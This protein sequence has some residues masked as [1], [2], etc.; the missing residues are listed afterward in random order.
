MDAGF[1][2]PAPEVQVVMQRNQL[3]HTVDTV[4]AFD[5]VKSNAKFESILIKIL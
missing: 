1:L 4:E 5:P 3:I 2:A